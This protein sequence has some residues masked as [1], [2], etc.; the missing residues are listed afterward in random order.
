MLN[1]K[2]ENNYSTSITSP[3]PGAYNAQNAYKVITYS[4][5]MP[6]GSSFINKNINPGPGTHE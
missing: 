6:L 4:A 2:R 3:G 5:G 1:R